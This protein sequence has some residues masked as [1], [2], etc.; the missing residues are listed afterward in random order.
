M[1]TE[2]RCVVLMA[3]CDIQVV[4]VGIYKQPFL[5]VFLHKLTVAPIILFMTAFLL[6]L[7]VT[8][9]NSCETNFYLIT[10]TDYICW[11]K[12]QSKTSKVQ[13]QPI[14]FRGLGD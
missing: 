10:Q 3:V 12:S 9:M 4:P 2:S 7:V 14:F 6:F 1:V 5:S 8:W 11:L 13:I